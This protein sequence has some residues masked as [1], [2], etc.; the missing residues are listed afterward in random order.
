MTFILPSL[1]APKAV[2]GW[3]RHAMSLEE[4]TLSAVNSRNP[5]LA[6][7]PFRPRPLE[8]DV[9]V[10]DSSRH[11]LVEKVPTP[12]EEE[13]HP[14][15]A[16]PAQKGTYPPSWVTNDGSIAGIGLTEIKGPKQIGGRIAHYFS[17]WD[18][19]TSD[20]FML[21]IVKGLVIDFL[22]TPRQNREFSPTLSKAQKIQ[23]SI[24]VKNPLEKGAV[25]KS[26]QVRI[27]SWAT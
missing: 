7:S 15:R 13:T 16:V 12:R 26:I 24:E 20:R 6:N 17:N 8:G 10:A 9:E 23:I 14:S 1:D 5:S 27:S 21:E 2:R 18:V 11:I 22:Q 4:Q 25:E 3:E 19:I